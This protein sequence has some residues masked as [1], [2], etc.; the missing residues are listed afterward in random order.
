M[1]GVF[2]SG[3][4][5]LTVVKKI[6]E[7]LPEYQILYFGDTARTPYG[8]R[9]EE[10]IKKFAYEAV[11]FLIKKGAKI[12]IIACNTV[13]AIATNDLKENFDL[14]IF[15][16]VTPAVEKAVA[17]TKNKRVGII[18]T[19]A[20]INSKIYEKLICGIDSSIKVFAQAAPL[21][22]PLIEEGWLKRGETKKILKSYLHPLKMV[23]VDTLIMACTH[24][25]LLVEQIQ[26]KIGH[27]VKLVNPSEEIALKL[28]NFL[29]KNQAI[30]QGLFKNQNHQFFISDFTPKFQQIANQW[31]GQNIKLQVFKQFN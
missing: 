31:L 17:V 18:G 11:D 12:I 27:K 14:P 9:S 6:F 7:I 8:E 10:I 13:S 24:Y 5:G 19:R 4:G 30:E 21:L 20:T 16:V 15:E 3:I 29:E 2:D 22:V 1:I 28:K 26:L 23:Q 25:P